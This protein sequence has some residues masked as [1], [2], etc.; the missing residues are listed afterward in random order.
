MYCPSTGMTWH[1]MAWHD[2][3]STLSFLPVAIWRR[4][5]HL[6]RT[7]ARNLC[8]GCFAPSLSSTVLPA[9]RVAQK[10][11]WD[12]HLHIC[13]ILCISW[14]WLGRLCRIFQ[15]R[16]HENTSL[17][18]MFVTNPNARLVHQCPLK[19]TGITKYHLKIPKMILKWSKMHVCKMYVASMFLSSLSLYLSLSLSASQWPSTWNVGNE[20]PP[21]VSTIKLLGLRLSKLFVVSKSYAQNVTKRLWARREGADLHR[22]GSWAHWIPYRLQRAAPALQRR[23]WPT[24]TA[25]HAAAELNVLRFSLIQESSSSFNCLKSQPVDQRCPQG[26]NLW[27]MMSVM[28]ASW[29]FNKILGPRPST[30][31]RSQ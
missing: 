19:A 22:H 2:M 3:W 1:D 21:G 15:Q 20:K 17:H 16:T 5:S 9:V 18:A 14:A 7:A 31:H 23:Q 10:R 26:S 25:F 30:W 29:M 12:S 24:G 27:P 11:P 8:L 6:I 28:S 4:V 13:N